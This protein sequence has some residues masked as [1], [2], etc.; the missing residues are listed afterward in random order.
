MDEHKLDF[1]K[2]KLLNEKKRFCDILNMMEEHKN[3]EQDRYA[4]GEL[5]NYDNH[6]ADL[7]TE[8]FQLGINMALKVNE[9]YN[10]SQIEDALNRID[11][12]TY[13]ICE[14]CKNEIDIER[15]ETLP[16]ARKCLTCENQSRPEVSSDKFSRP[17]E[18]SIIDAPFGRKYLNKREDD[19]YEGLDYLWDL[20]KYGNADSPQDLGGYNDYEEFYTNQVD[21]QGLVEGI[22]NISNEDYKKQLPD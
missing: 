3:G 8:V 2:Q 5:S 4:S 16:F 7:G 15:L 18:E 20:M 19:E 17:V 14:I 1:F 6:P 11:N 22:E 12:G 9:E 21:N 10:I 13:G